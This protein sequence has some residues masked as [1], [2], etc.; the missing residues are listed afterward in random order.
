MVVD[1]CLAL[2]EELEAAALSP[3]ASTAVKVLFA[4]D[5]YSSLY[6]QTGYGRTDEETG[7][8]VPLQV[9]DLTLVSAEP[10]TW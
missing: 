1:A 7:R 6:G 4:I 9:E 3:S 8:R 2:K 10:A 5:D